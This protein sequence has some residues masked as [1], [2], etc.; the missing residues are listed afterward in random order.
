MEKRAQEAPGAAETIADVSE[1]LSELARRW[2]GRR[3]GALNGYRQ[4]LSD[5]GAGRTDVRKTAS[6]ALR[7]T[8]EE[9]V[10]YPG[11]LLD[12]A[13]D[14]ASGVARM[15]GL[16]AKGARTSPGS[17]RAVH[18]LMLSGKIGE[19]A[20]AD[21]LIENPRDAEVTIG[22]AATAFSTDARVTK[23]TPS[24]D[25]PTCTLPPGSERKIAVSVK[26]DGRTVNAGETYAAQAVVDGFDDMV[27]RLNLAVD[28]A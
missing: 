24:F 10:K 17:Q 18:D 4:I 2:A 5:Y 6:A 20:T 1:L 27:L 22:F 9:A 14:Y 11:E 23:L 21:M 3:V 15:A 19:T 16:S 26:L 25:P 7:L 28:A 13:S 12:L 8:A